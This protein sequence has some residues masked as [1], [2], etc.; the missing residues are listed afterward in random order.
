MAHIGRVFLFAALFAVAG[1][2]PQIG[3]R[4]PLPN[5]PDPQRT[6]PSAV[7]QGEPIRVRVGSFIDGRRSDT[8]AVVDGREVG[9]E[10]PIGPVVQ[11]GFERYFRNA[12]ASV[13]LFK[14]PSIEGEVI[15]WRVAVTPQFPASAASAVARIKVEI[16]GEGAR[17][18]YRA[19][20]AGE[21]TASHPFLSEASVRELLATAMGSAIEEAVHDEGLV[22]ALSNSRGE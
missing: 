5:L 15:E 10:G 20:Y 21:A 11:E 16:R 7:G 6:V 8:I 2:A 1:C 14:A 13:V 9:S 19:T 22:I 18:A 3:L 17:V 12:G 4:I